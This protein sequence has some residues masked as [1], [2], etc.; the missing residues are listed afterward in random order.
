M[1]GVTEYLFA[2][3]RHINGQQVLEKGIDVTKHHEMQV[4]L[5]P[6]TY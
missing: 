1:N 3:R 2:Q 4:K 5:P 6:H